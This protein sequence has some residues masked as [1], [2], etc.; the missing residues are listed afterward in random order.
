MTTEVKTPDVTVENH[1]S[2]FLLRPHTPEAEDWIKEF[3]QDDAQT[4]GGA[5]VVEP[6]YV[7]VIVQGMIEHGL[8]LK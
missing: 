8:D 3:V 4:F 5:L 1:G 7:D 6:R 2:L